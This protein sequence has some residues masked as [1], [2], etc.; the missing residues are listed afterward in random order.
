M[1]C[2]TRRRLC[3]KRAAPSQAGRA[4]RTRVRRTPPRPNQRELWR[5][6]GA[7]LDGAPTQE[8]AR[9][10]H[11]PVAFAHEVLGVQPWS[12]QQEALAALA[13]EP[14]LTIRSSHGVGKTFLAATASLWFCYAKR[15]SMVLTTAPTARQ[16]EGQLWKEINRLWARAKV[17]LP[18]RCLSLRL[19]A[20]LDQTALGLTTN[21]PDKFAG[22]HEENLLAI[23]DEASGVPDNI[24]EVL[25]GTL[26]SAGCKLLL[27][28]NP[29]RPDGHF[30]MTHQRWP[31]RQKM[32][33]ASPD[34]PNF[35][36]PRG[37]PYPCPW[38]VTP[39]WVDARRE[40][41]GEDSDPWRVR[42]MG[43]FPLASP[44]ALIELAWVERA[45]HTETIPQPDQATEPR[46]LAL[47]VA[48][49]GDAE[50][51]AA[52]RH[53]DTLTA[54]LSWRGADLMATTGK[55]IALAREHGCQEMVID[56]VGLGG[57][58]Y[59][60]LLELQREDPAG[61]WDLTITPFGS[62]ERANEPMKYTNRRAE[63]YGALRERY[64][65]GSIDHASDWHRLTGQLTSLRYGY[66]S[67][68]ALAIETKDQL[69]KR[70][71]PSPDW[72]DAVAMAF[73]PSPGG[74]NLPMT[75]GHLRGA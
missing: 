7:Q 67:A 60:R 6:W 2:G 4:R 65:H 46:V 69:R 22:W 72:A 27:I 16:V 17:P 45:N 29:T 28:G 35:A 68:G 32:R 66:S 10:A 36:A 3:R 51:V 71:L 44:D 50:T 8:F 53:G 1:G 40:E 5:A 34:S 61:L 9:Y 25:K 24:Y 63:A 55:A 43:E 49:Y 12:K 42:V 74:F 11:D 57:G 15:P 58:V 13:R 75:A 54:V 39:E 48:R 73:A 19:E 23:V 37:G 26:T 41:W 70:G 59:D 33:L 20:S 47:D 30:A 64:Q 52:I 18:G 31:E 62:G 14:Q 21:E 38:L 56:T